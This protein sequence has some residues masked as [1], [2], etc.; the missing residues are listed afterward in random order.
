[1]IIA[2]GSTTTFYNP[3][4]MIGAG[5]MVLVL[6]L[7]GGKSNGIGSVISVIGGGIGKNKK[8]LCKQMQRLF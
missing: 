2:V 4:H 3:L 1:M 5:L 7:Y 8:S 6:V